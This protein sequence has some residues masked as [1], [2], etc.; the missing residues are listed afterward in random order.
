VTVHASLEDPRPLERPGASD[1]VTVAFG[2]PAANVFGVARVGTS[3]PEGGGDPVTSA[4][5]LLYAD[6]DLVAVRTGGVQTAIVEPLRAWRVTFEDE[7]DGDLGFELELR[8]A[9]AP[10]ELGPDH[11]AAVLGGMTGY[12][13][14][15]HVEGVARAG[16]GERRLRCLG[17]RGHSWGSPDW[18]RL[19]LARTLGVW[20]D[21]GLGVT[22]TAVRPAHA[23]HHGDE[24]LAC[25]LL[26]PAE[27]DGA[28]AAPVMVADPRLSTTY[29]GEGRQIAAG[30]EL[31]VHEDDGAPHRAAGEVLCGTTLDLG[32][33]RLDSAFLQWRMEGRTGIGRYDVLRR[34]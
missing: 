3:L 21:D 5:G 6:G 23:E 28:L 1:G 27:E 18:G 19:S 7:D 17:Q 13:Q 26:V 14:L 29:D 16:R 11:R 34:A 22:M 4:L 20:F 15:V 2:D 12:E 32:A 8:A 31:Y 24:A 30:L 25:S 9:S 33:L 10:A